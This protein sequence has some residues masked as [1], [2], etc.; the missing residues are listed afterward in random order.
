MTN[1]D[2]RTLCESAEP[3]IADRHKVQHSKSMISVTNLW[4]A[5]KVMGFYAAAN[6]SRVLALLDEI[7]RCEEGLDIA[8]RICD[9]KGINL[10]E[11]QDRLAEL[12]REVGEL[13]EGKAK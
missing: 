6:P 10:G 12:E 3:L 2:L 8:L 13:R 4:D 11:A 1:D 5:D 7:A 9:V